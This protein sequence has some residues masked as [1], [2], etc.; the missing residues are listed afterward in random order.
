MKVVPQPMVQQLTPAEVDTIHSRIERI[1]A[2]C[3]LLHK[4]FWVPFFF[5]NPHLQLIPYMLKNLLQKLY[6]PPVTYLSQRFK[7]QDGEVLTLDWV[8]ANLAA[9]PSSTDAT[10]KEPCTVLLLHHG[11]YGRSNDLPGF[12]YIEEATRRGWLVLAVNR[13]GHRGRLTQPN[14]NFFGNTSDVRYIVEECVRASRPNARVV[15]LG[16]SAGSGNIASYMGEQGL[17]I[18]QLRQR[19]KDPNE[20]GLESDADLAKKVYGYVSSV[21][22]VC[23][24]FNI[25]V[26]M[27]RFGPPYSTLLMSLGKAFFLKKNEDVL[28]KRTESTADV[29]DDSQESLQ[30][31][32]AQFLRK[33][34]FNDAMGATDLQFWLDS[35]YA[36]GSS[37]FKGD[38][39]ASGIFDIDSVPR[40]NGKV[41]P[42]TRSS[43]HYQSV[44]EYYDY[45]NPMRMAQHIVQPCL[46]LNA[47]D[48]PLCNILNVYE[49]MY[50]LEKN[51]IGAVCVTTKTG[52]HCS[53]LKA[54]PLDM[55]SWSEELMGQFFDKALTVQ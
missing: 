42:G 14:F 44:D 50:M 1:I 11:A 8:G 30:E 46:F 47:E 24:G 7:L 9:V 26:C 2:E 43:K 12:S 55:S 10:A 13:R 17:A 6:A 25:E 38:A 23:P 19:Q 34:C 52:S 3:S 49:S 4:T 39:H 31:Q 40:I 29:K 33:K 45:H 32:E 36:F 15:M 18:K 41:V 21:V 53:F 37:Y 27:R 16:I 54:N 35:M 51:S 22:G 48:D 20:G 5:H 28:L